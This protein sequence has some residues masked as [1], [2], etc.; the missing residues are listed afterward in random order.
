M[1]AALL[2]AVPV[3]MKRSSGLK[4][5]F[6]S[7]LR[8]GRLP[9]DATGFLNLRVSQSECDVSYHTH[10][11]G[12]IAVQSKAKQDTDGEQAELTLDRPVHAARDERVAVER[13][14][15]AG[16][17]RV[18]LVR[19]FGRGVG[20][21]KVGPR[22]PDVDRPVERR[23]DN[24]RAIGRVG[25]RGDARLAAALLG[26]EHDRRLGLELV[27]DVPYPERSVSNARCV[28]DSVTGIDRSCKCRAEP[29]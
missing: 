12:S 29:A 8:F 18:L 15:D 3:M 25:G 16:D 9:T 19:A 2:P 23:R 24:L 5:M 27:R 26:L 22:A 13:I 21:G 10:E 14:G 11:P 20:S 4:M 1:I 6:D 17:R 28:R 7:A